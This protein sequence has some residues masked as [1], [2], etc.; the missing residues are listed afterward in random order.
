VL[1]LALLKQVERL[2]LAGTTTVILPIFPRS[3]QVNL[4]A[5]FSF[6]TRAKQPRSFHAATKPL[7]KHTVLLYRKQSSLDAVVFSIGPKLD[8][9]EP[10]TCLKDVMTRLSTY[11]ASRITE[12]LP[13]HWQ[14][15]AVL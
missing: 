1:E 7:L 15:A 13:H 4:H 14:I 6:S 5:A 8:N 10:H 11:K 2:V 3:Q 9:H 12:L